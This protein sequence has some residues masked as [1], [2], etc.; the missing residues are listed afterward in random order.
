MS[1]Q[2]SASIEALKERGM[3]YRYIRD[4]FYGRDVLEVETPL[5]SHAAVSDAN[6]LPV[7]VQCMGKASYLHTSP[8]YPMKRLLASGSGDIFQI[9]KVFR[10]EELGS[11]HNP[12]FSM[13]EYY[14]L[15]FKDRKSVV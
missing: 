7:V 15:H 6:L 8:E 5:L 12:E 2:P 11:R 13:L 10:D 1:W 4:F 9:S 3:F 14:R